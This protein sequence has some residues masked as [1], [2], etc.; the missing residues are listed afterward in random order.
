MSGDKIASM[1]KGKQVWLLGFSSYPVANLLKNALAESGTTT[2]VERITFDEAR[3]AAKSREDC[4]GI[5]VG[6]NYHWVR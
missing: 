4:N 6:D 1:E 2:T 3:E 5:K